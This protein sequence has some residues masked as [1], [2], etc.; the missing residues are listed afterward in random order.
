MRYIIVAVFALFL[1]ACSTT[2][3]IVAKFP[4]APATLLES[5]PKELKAIEGDTVNIIDLTKTV[6]ANYET[7][8]LCADKSESWIEWYNIQ[9]KIFEEVN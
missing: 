5:C 9:K 8:H 6:V 3:P 2:V 1:S 7:Y 4:D